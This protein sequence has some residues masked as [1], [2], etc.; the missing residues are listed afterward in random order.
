MPSFRVYVKLVG[1]SILLQFLF[2]LGN[3]LGSWRL[4]L[5]AKESQQRT[6]QILRIVYWCYGILSGQLLLRHDN[7]P[8]PAIYC[9]I[10]ALRSAS[11]KDHLPSSRA[12]AKYSRLAVALRK[13]FQVTQ[14]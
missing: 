6:G 3:L 7:S 14:T 1:L 8:A 11:N 9:R 12:G 10:E 5:L 13:R 2:M 4:I